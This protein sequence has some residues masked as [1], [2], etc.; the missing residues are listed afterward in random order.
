VS[1]AIKKLDGVDSVDVSLEKGSVTIKL[2]TDNKVTLP[3]LRRTIRSNGNEPK[4]AQIAG[5]GKIVD[6]DGKRIFDLL[7]GATM[8][9]EPGPKAAP[10]GVVEVTGVSRERSR[11][12]ERVTLTE[13]R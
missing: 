3:Q 4:D 9:V 2:R 11:D 1:A 10:G 12:I 7:N 6:T 8:E 13:V 5:R